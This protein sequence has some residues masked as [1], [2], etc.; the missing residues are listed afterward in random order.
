MLLT[1]LDFH[2]S[3]HVLLTSQQSNRMGKELWKLW[4]FAIRLYTRVG[5]SAIAIHMHSE[6]EVSSTVSNRLHLL[7]VQRLERLLKL[8]ENIRRPSLSYFPAKQFNNNNWYKS[9]VHDTDH[10]YIYRNIDV[11]SASTPLF[12]KNC[13][14]GHG[15]PRYEK[16][17]HFDTLAKI[18]FLAPFRREI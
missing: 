8:V 17:N 2:K 6:V 13:S 14:S 11:R 15:W 10:V 9:R 16:T 12:S 18:A 1:L 7:A 4:T 5:Y 3:K